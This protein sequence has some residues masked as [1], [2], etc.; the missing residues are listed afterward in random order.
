MSLSLACSASAAATSATEDLGYIGKH[1]SSTLIDISPAR[2]Q[3]YIERTGDNHPWYTGDS[4]FG[5][6]VAPAHLFPS[7]SSG[8]GWFLPNMHGNLHA[9][10]EW[11]YYGPMMVGS[12]VLATRTVVDRYNKRGRVYMVCEVSFSD[13]KTGQLLARNRHHQSFLEDQ[14]EEAIQAW[15]DGTSAERIAAMEEDKPE[16]KGDGGGQVISKERARMP[17]PNEVGDVVETFGPVSREATLEFTERFAGT[18]AGESFGN[19][20]LDMKEA[21]DMG[22]PGIVVV[23]VL[24]VCF[25]SELMTHRFGKGWF[26]GGSMDIKMVRPLW[27]GQT[28]EAWGVVREWQA[29]G[30]HRRRAICEIWCQ[31]TDDQTVT[32]VATA[33]AFE[34]LPSRPKL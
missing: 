2:V 31:N 33:Q 26:E 8:G 23:G 17:A 30:P 25:L 14:S 16:G 6:P 32:Q 7:H 24:S 18:K 27:M 20:H 29:D 34:D 1:L 9:R 28:V 3:E 21:E 10:Q 12:E 19:G 22:F 4:P 13:S 15:Q 11:E 5:G